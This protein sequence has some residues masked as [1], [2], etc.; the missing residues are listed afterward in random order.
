M[1]PV[2]LGDL[3]K[4]E[5]QESETRG[6]GGE[7]RASSFETFFSEAEPRLR[8]ALV[9]AYGVQRGREATATPCLYLGTL[10]P[11]QRNADPMGYLYRVAQSKVRTR[12]H[13]STFEI[14]EDHGYLYEPN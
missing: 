14:P 10:G 2:G 13:R 9:A 8:R 7:S 12:R 1:A 3:K 11:A 4:Q 5:P 6:G